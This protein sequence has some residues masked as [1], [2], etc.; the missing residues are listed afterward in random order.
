MKMAIDL[1]AMIAVEEKID[2][3]VDVTDEDP[4][5][6]ALV[7]QDVLIVVTILIRIVIMIVIVVAVDID[8]VAVPIDLTMVTIANKIEEMELT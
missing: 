1:T 5:L 4:L 7:H 6:L 8:N 2:T 3:I